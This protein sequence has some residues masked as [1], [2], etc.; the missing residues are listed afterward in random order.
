MENLIVSVVVF[1]VTL[2]VLIYILGVI[3]K[4]LK[5]IINNQNIIS[6]NQVDIEKK[7]DKL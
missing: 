2:I 3:P 7:I 4:R 6:K 1:V 5:K